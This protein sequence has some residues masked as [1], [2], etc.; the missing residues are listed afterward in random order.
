MARRS[1]R[2]A[3]GAAP[4]KF[5]CGGRGPVA[6]S[7]AGLGPAERSGGGG[8]GT[9]Q[10]REDGPGV[11]HIASYKTRIKLNPNC[12]SEHARQNDP[13]WRL[14][15]EAIEAA[16]ADLGGQVVTEITDYYSRHVPCDFGIVTP[17]WPRGVGIRVSPVTGEVTFLYDPYED[18]RGAAKKIAETVTQSYT[19]LAVAQALRA[20][21]YEVEM[22][23]VTEAADGSR[24]VLVRGVL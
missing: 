24:A 8:S 2:A 22:D 11:S 14:M 10:V 23:Q 1:V 17:Q 16:A 3:E 6:A 13:T 21:N 20:L 19:A 12:T 4:T 15:R 5:R 18:R 9:H 7:G